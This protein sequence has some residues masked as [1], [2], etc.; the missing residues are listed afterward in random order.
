[1][2]NFIHKTN[3]YL[4]ERYP[5]IWNTK[6]VWML[7]IGISFHLL[8]FI[9]GYASIPSVLTLH[10]RD[11]SY[12][13][14]AN[15]TI[16]FS[17]IISMLSIVIW[18]IYLF[19][20]NAFKNYYPTHNLDILKNALM[21]FIIFFIHISYY[22]SHTAGLKTRIEF[23]YSDTELIEDVAT[24][25]KAAVFLSQNPEN[26]TLNNIEYPDIFQELYCKQN[27]EYLEDKPHYKLLGKTYQYYSVT[28]KIIAKDLNDYSYSSL[29]N[30]ESNYV[31]QRRIDDKHVRYFYKD[32]VV[33]VSSYLPKPLP[34]ISYYYYNSNFYDV[35]L[36][37]KNTENT[38]ENIIETAYD[39]INYNHDL[40]QSYI[41][42]KN[43]HE[44]LKRKDTTE[45]KKILADF[46]SIANKYKVDVNITTNQWFDLIYNPLNFE[47]KH[48]IKTEKPTLY[49]AGLNSG[50]DRDTE[51]SSYY[52]AHV[53]NFYIDKSQLKNTFENIENV[54][55]LSIFDPGFYIISIV[56]FS[57]AMILFMFRITNLRVFI[58]TFITVFVL[59]IVISLFSVLILSQS[60][61]NFE[62][63]PLYLILLT[64]TSIIA[65]SFSQGRMHKTIKG[66]CI[67]I[68]ASG[69]GLYIFLILGIISI[70]Q[71]DY[72]RTKYATTSYEHHTILETLNIFWIP[73]ILALSFIFLYFYASI[74]R[75]WKAEP[76]A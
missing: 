71:N 33:D 43:T 31:F 58:F 9:I 7:F 56:A 75:R 62:Y 48:F 63:V 50:Y 15:G 69:I 68:T 32:T 21:Y 57:L 8:F 5:N 25:N 1:M 53:S 19:K 41:N 59:S 73:I 37:D 23:S 36:N 51:L 27:G 49:S 55:N 45:I 13:F 16:Y 30:E 12:S 76:E 11:I 52:S 44:L 22:F 38:T 66:I 29:K 61:S 40:K 26:Y 47:V 60:S 34:A 14:F 2:N 35:T 6:F 28:S 17:I 10:Q 67:N 4:I 18:M 65:I 42:N 20:N 3:Q 74:I 70:H 54:K 39:Y 72:F 64:S 46:L 24:A